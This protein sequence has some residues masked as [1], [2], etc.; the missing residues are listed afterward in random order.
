M[1]RHALL[2]PSSA[3]RWTSCPPSAR[4]CEHIEEGPSLFAEEGTEAHT[5]CE[6]KVRLALGLPAQDPTPTLGFYNEQ[7]ED[8]ADEYTAFV[9]EAFQQEEDAKRDPII[10]LEQKVDISSYVPE[11]SGTADCI[12]ISDAHL[13]VID[14]KYGQGV[15]VSA[16]RNTQMMLYAL[17]AIGMFSSLYEME[18]VSMTVFQPRL[19]NVGTFTMDVGELLEWADSFLKPRAELAFTGQGEFCSGPHC[20]FC[21][22]KATCRKRAEANLDL[23]RYEFAK[24]VLLGDHEIAEILT[25]ADELASWVSD[26][27]AYAFSLLE[28]GGT[29]EGFKLVEGRSIRRYTDEAAAAEAVRSAGFDPY[30]HKVLGITAMTNLLGRT[31][32]NEILGSHV[33]KPKGK[34]TLVPEGDKRPAIT[35]HDFME[36]K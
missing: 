34:P 24:P 8:C 22:V 33:V 26:V 13:H 25:Q 21:K 31:R 2:S 16:E 3:A 9:L 14:F 10:L 18:T 30:E 6:Y 27:K 23:A 12:I 29:L 17:G 4:L 28:K 19:A 32:F 36:E 35:I 11:C 20:R 5:L 1:A 7:M 15:P